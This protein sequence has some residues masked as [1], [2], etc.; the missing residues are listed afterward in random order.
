MHEAHHTSVSAQP[1][2]DVQ[3][4]ANQQPGV[5]EGRIT[6]YVLPDGRNKGEHRPAIIVKTWGSLPHSAVNMQVFVDGLN[7]YPVDH[8]ASFTGFLWKTSVPYSENKEP[9]TWHWIEQ[10]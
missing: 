9:G 8:A 6:H 2:H 10:A 1:H 3:P 5:I 4:H 7:D